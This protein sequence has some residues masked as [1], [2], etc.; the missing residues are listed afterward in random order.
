MNEKLL[1]V[2][3][4]F[5]TLNILVIPLYIVIYLDVSFPFLQNF[6]ASSL[7]FI[8]SKFD[9]SISLKDYYLFVP[10]KTEKGLQVETFVISFD[11]TGW[12]T[13]YL[14]F[15]LVLATLVATNILKTYKKLK[16]LIFGLPFLFFRPY[17]PKL[18]RERLGSFQQPQNSFQ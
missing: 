10:F 6:L 9:S 1:R 13:M 5:I 7:Y 18:P 14:F 8:L 16:I 17:Q 4:F 15:A 11:C 2:L 12:K 3:I